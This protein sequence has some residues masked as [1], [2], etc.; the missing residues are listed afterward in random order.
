MMIKKL[1]VLFI[2][3]LFLLS[4]LVIVQLTSAEVDD[5]NSSSLTWQ[6]AIQLTTNGNTPNG[7]KDPSVTISPSGKNVI[8]AYMHRTTANTDPNG[9]NGPPTEN[10]TDPYYTQ[11]ND[12][13]ENWSTPA[14][15]YQ[16]SNVD[17]S[18]VTTTFDDD[19]VAQATWVEADNQIWYSSQVSSTW[20]TTSATKLYETATPGGTIVNAPILVTNLNDTLDLVWS[21][22]EEASSINIYHARATDEND[23]NIYNWPSEPD[24]APIWNTASGSEQ[25]HA[26]VDD[27][28]ILHVV[29]QEQDPLTPGGYSINYAQFNGT[30]WTTP[31]KV[32]DQMSGIPINERQYSLPQI[33]VQG[34]QINV[35]FE[36]RVNNSNQNV[37]F[38]SCKNNCA[39]VVGNWSGSRVSTI[40]YSLNGDDPTF[41]RPQM[42][43][44]G[45]CP[46]VIFTSLDTG[47]EAEEHIRISSGCEGWSNNNTVDSV[48]DLV[49]TNK[50]AIFPAAATSNGWFT[51]LAF[52]IKDGTDDS[53]ISHIYVTRNQ[54]GIYLPVV[55]K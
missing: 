46:I 36:N 4:V 10:Q 9:Q 31:I 48:N 19:L 54:P 37:F 29:W 2:S 17:S 14:K 49:G 15:I 18:F 52:Q 50:R 21:Q 8:V 20:G 1:S 7:A 51:Q 26:F 35:A 30:S 5:V 55:L 38:V 39:T 41:L 16:S 34:S 45:S 3:F 27:A 23:D 6:A 53:D 43:M 32:S 40:N 33:Y 13:G 42:V 22:A 12:Y 44:T 28:G 47:S 24:D 11:S 25:P